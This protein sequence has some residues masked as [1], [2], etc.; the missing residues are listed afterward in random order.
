MPLG[1][2][3]NSV[4]NGISEIPIANLKTGGESG[5]FRTC[6]DYIRL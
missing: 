2:H 4:L 6:P 3:R 5:V 1:M